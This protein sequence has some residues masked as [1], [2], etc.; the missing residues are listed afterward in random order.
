MCGDDYP[1]SVLLAPLL[2]RLVH[3]NMTD[4][5]GSNKFSHP[6][7]Q[8]QSATFTVDLMV[9]IATVA[10]TVIVNDHQQN[11]SPKQN[12]SA[13][14][15]VRLTVLAAHTATLLDAKYFDGFILVRLVIV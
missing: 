10:E 9:P 15:S 2:N 11:Q 8:L 7:N 5:G 3:S 13:R 6:L 4:S 12:Q 1:L 14:L